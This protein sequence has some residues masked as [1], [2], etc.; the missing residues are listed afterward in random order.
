MGVHTLENLVPVVPQV[1]AA[2]K[3]FRLHAGASGQMDSV[4][5]YIPH[6][7]NSHRS[8]WM[9]CIS[10]NMAGDAHIHTYKQHGASVAYRIFELCRGVVEPL[11]EKALQ[12][13]SLELKQTGRWPRGPA[14]GLSRANMQHLKN[15]C[16]YIDR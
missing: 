1:G 11:E 7:S 9:H 13:V 10:H 16:R 12:G 6:D 14:E 4:S 3:W 8:V 5:N 15:K 2:S